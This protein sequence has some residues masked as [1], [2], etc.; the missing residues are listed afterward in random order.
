MDAATIIINPG[1]ITAIGTGNR[2]S[3]I[4]MA[5]KAVITDAMLLSIPEFTF[6]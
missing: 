2:T 3:L 6:S 5:I 4:A 1:T